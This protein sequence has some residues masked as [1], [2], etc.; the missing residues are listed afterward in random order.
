[1]EADT[2]RPAC[3]GKSLDTCLWATFFASYECV[4]LGLILTL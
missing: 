1:M 4:G 3:R 2:K